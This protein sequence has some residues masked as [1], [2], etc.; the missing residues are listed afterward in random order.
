MQNAGED[1]PKGSDKANTAQSGEDATDSEKTG[2][3]KTPG[4]SAMAVLW[5]FGKCISALL[6]VYLAGYYRMSTS[7]VVFGLMVYSGWKHS[8]EAKEARL[9]SAIQFFSNEQEYTTTKI[10]KSKRDVPAWV[11]KLPK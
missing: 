9:R 2:T 7:F 3:P 1:G 5:T 10:F 11:R 8:R 6:P 4:I